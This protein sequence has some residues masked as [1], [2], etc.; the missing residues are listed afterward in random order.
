MFP[1]KELTSGRV[2]FH[3]YLSPVVSRQKANLP[4]NLENRSDGTLEGVFFCFSRRLQD[5][6]SV[7][8]QY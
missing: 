7:Q 5:I 2:A 3:F 6:P 8:Y 4:K 1:I